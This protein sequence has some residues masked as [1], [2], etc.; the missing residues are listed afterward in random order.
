MCA[1]RK[2]FLHRSLPAK[3]VE[4]LHHSM[5]LRAVHVACGLK[6]LQQ[7]QMHSHQVHLLQ[8][9]HVKWSHLSHSKYCDQMRWASIPLIRLICSELC[10][11]VNECHSRVG[12]PNVVRFCTVI[13]LTPSL[14]YHTQARKGECILSFC[15]CFLRISR[16]CDIFFPI[17]MNIVIHC[18]SGT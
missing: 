7:C 5:K 12:I 11:G 17:F 18:L 2:E 8:A 9:T 4:I 10:M 14:V 3:V 13:K 6:Y 1:G 15:Y 16:N